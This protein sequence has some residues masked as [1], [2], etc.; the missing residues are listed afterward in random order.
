MIF[1]DFLLIPRR[2][3]LTPKRYP[4]PSPVHLQ[5]QFCTDPEPPLLHA[6]E[7]AV[8]DEPGFP[9]APKRAANLV[10]FTKNHCIIT[11]FYLLS[12]VLE[13]FLIRFSSYGFE[14]LSIVLINFIDFQVFSD[15]QYRPK[16]YMDAYETMCGTISLYQT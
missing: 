15:C 13:S 8:I 4:H 16:Y 14:M 11:G 3:L 10:L 9:F 6:A 5:Q 12:I 2:V 1:E 7:T